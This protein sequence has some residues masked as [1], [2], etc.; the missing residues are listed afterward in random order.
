MSSLKECM[1]VGRTN[2]GK[3]LLFLN[4]AES[5]GARQIE[6]RIRRPGV[7][8]EEIERLPIHAARMRLVGGRRHQTRWLQSIDLALP[9]GKGRRRFR[10]T[11]AAGLTDSIHEADDVRMAVA[12]ALRELRQADLVV[13]VLDAAAIGERGGAEALPD[14]DVQISRYAPLRAP[15]LIVANKMDLPWAVTGLAIIRRTFAHQRVV[16]VSALERTG[17]REVKAF[18]WDHL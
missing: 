6:L 4:F 18:V 12:Q 15:Y 10:L 2:V 17:F 7:P 5:C 9:K 13:H 3:T 16:P 11:D 8:G 14:I 1:L